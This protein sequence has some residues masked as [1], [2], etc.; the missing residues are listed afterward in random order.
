MGTALN[1][2]LL[3]NRAADLTGPT[4]FTRPVY[5]HTHTSHGRN[6]DK[7]LTAEMYLRVPIN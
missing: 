7:L 5:A 3:S 6:P 4:S 1:V 2:V